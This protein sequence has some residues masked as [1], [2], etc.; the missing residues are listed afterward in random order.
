MGKQKVAENARE[1]NEN[2]NGKVQE[3][4]E[5][6]SGKLTRWG[7]AYEAVKRMNSH[8]ADLD[9][10]GKLADRLYVESHDGDEDDS[11]VDGATAKV[12]GVLETIERLG[13]VEMKWKCIVVPKIDLSALKLNK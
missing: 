6:N 12:Q 7:A 11:D 3:E 8:E 2:T 1:V 4:Q 5:T 10:L 9:D 13:L